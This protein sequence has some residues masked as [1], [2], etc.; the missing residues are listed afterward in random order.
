[1]ASAMA[2]GLVAWHAWTDLHASSPELLCH[3]ADEALLRAKQNGRDRVELYR[4]G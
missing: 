2:V 3:Q 4:S 1:M